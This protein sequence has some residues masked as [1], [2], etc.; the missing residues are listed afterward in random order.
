MAKDKL[1]T[2]ILGLNNEGR[3]LLEAACD[4]GL[5]EIT[6]VGDRDGEFAEKIAEKYLCPSFDDYRQLVIQSQLDVLF[7]IDPLSLCNEY[8]HSAIKKGVN[9]IKL[10]PPSLNFEQMAELSGLCKKENVKYIVLNRSRFAPGFGALRDFL[11]SGGCA[12]FHLIDALCNEPF[13]IKDSGDRWLSDPK[14]AGGGVLLRNC[15]E[16]IDVMISNFGLPQQIYSLTTNYAPDKQQRLSTTEDSAVVT[17]KFSDTLIGNII[18]SRVLGPRK[19]QINVYGKEK[20]LSATEDKFTIFDNMGQI[21]ENFQYQNE[22]DELT[23]EML[24]NIGLGLLMPETNR[25]FGNVE[26]DLSNMA[27]IESAYLSS[28][29]A[30]PEEPLRI[31]NMIRPGRQHQN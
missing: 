9:I 2:G 25:I 24:K 20:Y 1:K 11:S 15:Y 16:L 21:V 12:D 7:V 19:A 6:A 5:F 4:T 13:P 17:M 26:E 31:L 3:L 10:I 22:I 23:L 30:M 8:V 14:L 28:R 29:T 27:V 18:S